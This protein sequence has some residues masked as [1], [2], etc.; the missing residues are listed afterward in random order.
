[1][2]GPSGF[3]VVGFRQHEGCEIVSSHGTAEAAVA[4]LPGRVVGSPSRMMDF[5]AYEIVDVAT[6]EPV[7]TFAWKYDCS[8]AP[9]FWEL[10]EV[11][12]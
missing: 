3:L 4:S 1:M 8:G 2:S 12:Q 5:D 7:K 9:V 10:R 6:L 11:T